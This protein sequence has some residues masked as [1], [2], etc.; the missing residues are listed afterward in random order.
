VAA[1]S[2]SDACFLLWVSC[3]AKRCV[4]GSSARLDAQERLRNWWTAQDLKRFQE[5]TACVARQFDGY[6]IE[7]S[8]HHYGQL[9]LG[10]SIADLAGVRVSC[11][12]FQK[13]QQQHP[14]PTVDG[15]TPNQQFF[16]AW[17][18]G[19]GEKTRRH[20]TAVARCRIARAFSCKAGD[21][22]VR[23]GAERCEVW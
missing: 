7:P 5:R 14:A 16:I 4:P 9:V 8:I 20:R 17:G 15:L 10:E 23:S 21:P 2:S 22:M 11:R 1:D 19:R 6:F 13:A 3:G 18:Q 12:A